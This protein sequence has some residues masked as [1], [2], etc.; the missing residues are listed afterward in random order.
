MTLFKVYNGVTQ[1]VS[2]ELLDSENFIP[3]P[4]LTIIVKLILLN[5]S[6]E[7]IQSID[8]NQDKRYDLIKN[9]HFKS[10]PIIIFENLYDY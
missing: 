2:K 3:A 5:F 8:L 10:K 4:T 9:N 1:L 7:L 6:H